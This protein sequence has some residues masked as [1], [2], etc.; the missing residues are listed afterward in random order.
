MSYMKDKALTIRLS[1]EQLDDLE[2]IAKENDASVAWVVRRAIDE[3][4]KRQG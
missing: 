2:R 1:S 4:R 3:Y